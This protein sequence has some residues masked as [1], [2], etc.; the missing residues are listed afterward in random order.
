MAFR[1]FRILPANGANTLREIANFGF[2]NIRG[3]YTYEL[4]RVIDVGDV[5]FQS[6]TYASF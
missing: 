4:F 2:K 3:Y 6:S 5:I 1:E